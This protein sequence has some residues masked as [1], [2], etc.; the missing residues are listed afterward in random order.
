[1]RK[2]IDQEG[3]EH[4]ELHQYGV[5]RQYGFL[6]LR[7][8]VWAGWPGSKD[9]KHDHQ[10]HGADKYILIHH[11]KDL[12]LFPL[13]GRPEG[14]VGEKMAKMFSEEVKSDNQSAILGDNGSISHPIRSHS[15]FHDKKVVADHI[16]HI[17]ED[18]N[19][20]GQPGILHPQEETKQCKLTQC[21][22]SSPYPDSEIGHGQF[23]HPGFSFQY[24]KTQDFYGLLECQQ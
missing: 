21:R 20:H 23:L 18:Q 12:K 9:G 14:P 10:A 11:Q 4:K 3:E 22:G 1:M 5:D 15:K 6:P 19:E 13:C 16:D 2:S 17:G 7:Q 8:Q 24:R